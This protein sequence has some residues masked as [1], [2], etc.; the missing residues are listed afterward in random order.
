MARNRYRPGRTVAAFFIGLALA[1]GLVALNGTWSPKLGLDLQGGTR[2]TLIATGSPTSAN[3]EEARGIIDQRVNGSG[4][5][6]AEV[7]RQGN[8]FVV[9]EIPGKT[10]Q[11]LVD[12]VK[13]QAQMRFRLV[14]CS[15]SDGKCGTATTAPGGPTG[16]PTTQPSIAP[17]SGDQQKSGKSSG[18]NRAPLAWA[19]KTKKKNKTQPSSSASPSDTASPSPSAS[20][21]TSAGTTA[22]GSQDV[23]S[24]TSALAWMR[25]PDAAAKKAFDSYT[26]TKDSVSQ[27]V[28]PD[29]KVVDGDAPG[30][31]LLSCEGSQKYLLS[32]AVIE[33]TE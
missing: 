20:P 7:T 29:G 22:P 2:I 13:R 8:R 18:K 31:P 5:S 11:S 9:V 3:L 33:G 26:C 17:S 15:A 12:T 4:V 21:S 6:E 27:N 14:A 16:L 1:F 10:N 25:N 23:A 30:L 28:M 24:V 32:P 19:E